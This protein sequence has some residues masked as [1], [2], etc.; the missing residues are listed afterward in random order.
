MSD[1]VQQARQAVDNRLLKRR[2][3]S[4]NIEEEDETSY[5]P[6]NLISGV[7]LLHDNWMEPLFIQPSM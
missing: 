7:E 4:K 5:N 1:D 6:I 3:K 2:E